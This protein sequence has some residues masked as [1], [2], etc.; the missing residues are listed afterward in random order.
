MVG[1]P[2]GRR[3]W[4]VLVLAALSVPLSGC[5]GAVVGRWRLAQAVPNRETF[6]LDN[7]EFRND[8]TFS[9]RT[10]IEGATR[11]ESGTFDYN[12]SKLKLRPKEGGQRTYAAM[13]R[14][15]RLEIT[16]GKRH[17][18]LTRVAR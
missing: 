5:A 1:Q 14:F 11:D 7:V 13:V 3:G 10:T 16:H 17:V 6:S 8:G 15:G 12:G 2:R 9:A 18:V 4:Q